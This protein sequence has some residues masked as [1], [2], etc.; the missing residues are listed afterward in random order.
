MEL[1]RDGTLKHGYLVKPGPRQIHEFEHI[2]GDSYRKDAIFMNALLLVRFFPNRSFVIHNLSVIESQET[3]SD[4]RT[5]A[6][7][8]ELGQVIYEY[9]GIPKEFTKDALREVGQL[10]DAWT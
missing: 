5:L 7:Q 4:I 3:V 9:F 8:D 10:G 2:I 6:S 1:F